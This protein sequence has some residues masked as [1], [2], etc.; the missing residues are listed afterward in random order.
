MA[1]SLWKRQPWDEDAGLRLFCVVALVVG[2]AMV[3]FTVV[4]GALLGAAALVVPFFGGMIAGYSGA[5]L[6]LLWRGWI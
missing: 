5:T 1:M 2:I 6:L 4:F 3:A